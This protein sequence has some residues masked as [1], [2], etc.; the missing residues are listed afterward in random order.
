MIEITIDSREQVIKKFVDALNPKYKDLIEIDIRQLDTADFII[1]NTISNKEIWVERKSA[2]DFRA[3]VF[4]GRLLEQLS[5]LYAN[6]Y[7]FIIIHGDIYDYTLW[8]HTNWRPETISKFLSS[9]VLK[10]S[11]EGNR[12][13]IF[14]VPNFQHFVTI[15]ENFIDKLQDDDLIRLENIKIY[16]T[17][18][19]QETLEQIRL[20]QLLTIP[21]L[22]KQKA[23][24]LLDHFNHN[25]KAIQN[26]SQQE[27]Q[28]VKGIG[29]KLAET[30]YKVFNP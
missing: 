13:G 27:L 8:Q 25:Y 24:A 10:T 30:I 6:R 15:I 9:L 29:K 2:D 14:T 17:P 21:K 11:I 3:S 5:R 23:K 22:G 7:S 28:E 19:R 1:K 26:A 12:I 4:D 16:N 18:T 20:H